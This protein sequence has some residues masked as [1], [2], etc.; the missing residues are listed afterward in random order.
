MW[1]EI[2]CQSNYHSEPKGDTP[3]FPSHISKTRSKREM[4]FLF[5]NLWSSLKLSGYR[6]RKKFNREK[7]Q[8]PQSAV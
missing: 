5:I 6:L 1:F 2:N 4:E 3:F 8:I 7:N